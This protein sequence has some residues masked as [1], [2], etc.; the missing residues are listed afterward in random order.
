[1]HGRE[2]Q[3]IPDME[4]HPKAQQDRL[5]GAIMPQASN[6]LAMLARLPSPGADA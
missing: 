1:M 5:H 4:Q 3:P 6:R 2:L